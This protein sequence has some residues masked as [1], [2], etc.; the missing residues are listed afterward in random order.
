MW[1]RST[2]SLA[3]PYGLDGRSQRLAKDR[4]ESV[5]RLVWAWFVDRIPS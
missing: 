2:T 3:N 4:V 1:F 5:R